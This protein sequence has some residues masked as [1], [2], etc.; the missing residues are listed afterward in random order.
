[1]MNTYPEND[2][3]TFL[4]HSIK[5]SERKNH[6]YISRKIGKS[7]KWIYTYSSSPNKSGSGKSGL[8]GSLVSSIKN[9]LSIKMSD[10]RRQVTAA[11]IKWKNR[12][13]KMPSSIT[14]YGKGEKAKQ[15]ASQESNTVR[16]SEGNYGTLRYRGRYASRK[17]R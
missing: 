14:W 4:Q 2:Y 8:K 10:A 13:D 3:R 1:M 7:G 16:D 11:S 15:R 17:P 5:G 12:N 6:K 9:A